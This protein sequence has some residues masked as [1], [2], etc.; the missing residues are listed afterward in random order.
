MA[1]T[2][3]AVGLECQMVLHASSVEAVPALQGAD[4]AAHVHQADG[5]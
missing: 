4:G 5:T 2:D 1:S 3:G